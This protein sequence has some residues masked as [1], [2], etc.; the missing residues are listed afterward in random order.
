M[1]VKII[2]FAS[3]I[4]TLGVTSTA[5][6]ENVEGEVRKVHGQFFDGILHAD[7]ELLDQVLSSDVTLSFP[8]GN[9]M[10]RSE[11]LAFLSG[12]ELI[13]DSADHHA[14]NVR[15]Y[16][17]AAVVHGKSTLS[18]RWSRDGETE[19]LTESLTYTATYILGDAG[20]QMVAWQSTMP[21]RE[22]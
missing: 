16:E 17:S 22:E 13:Y 1:M 12:G 14:V 6:S 20:W 4:L 8:G 19:H 15:V 18:L 21:I 7:T 2:I 3:A 9:V 10:P 5:S 11:F